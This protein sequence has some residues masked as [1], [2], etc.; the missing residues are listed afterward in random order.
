[1]SSSISTSSLRALE[2]SV[3]RLN[4]HPGNRHTRHLTLVRISS[5]STALGNTMPCTPC[6]LGR[7]MHC[8]AMLRTIQLDKDPSSSGHTHDPAQQ[9][10]PAPSTAPVHEC[11]AQWDTCAQQPPR[12]GQRD[13]HWL[14]CGGQSILRIEQRTTQPRLPLQVLVI[15]V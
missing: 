3:D 10:T 7:Q 9:S 15:D 13:Q 1:M 4:Q 6:I 8:K 12:W 11:R 14:S 5:A 2:W